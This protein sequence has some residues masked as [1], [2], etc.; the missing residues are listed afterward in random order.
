VLRPSSFES[1][2]GGA[3]MECSGSKRLF[4]IEVLIV[5]GEL[6]DIGIPYTFL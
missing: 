1:G 2:L 5:F 3:K 6:G 4:L